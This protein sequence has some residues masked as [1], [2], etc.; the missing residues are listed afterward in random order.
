MTEHFPVSTSKAARLPRVPVDN[1]QKTVP[2]PES[3]DR[4]ASRFESAK[5]AGRR[6]LVAADITKEVPSA[7]EVYMLKYMLHGI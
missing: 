3:I 5:L 1:F 4:P 7:A 2:L 6:R